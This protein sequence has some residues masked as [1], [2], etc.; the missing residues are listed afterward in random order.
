LAH[1]TTGLSPYRLIFDKIVGIDGLT[2]TG[3]DMAGVLVKS[4]APFTR[5][6][7]NFYPLTK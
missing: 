4:V 5:G 6:D 2:N 7:S 3:V 1:P